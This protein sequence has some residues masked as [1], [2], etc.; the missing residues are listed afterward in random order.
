MDRPAPPNV[1]VVQPLPGI[2]DMIW[3]L[4]H[5]RAIAHHVGAPVTLLAKP[6]SLADQIFQAETTIRDV[7]WVDRNP[8]RRQG[9]HDGSRGWFRLVASLRAKRFSDVF[10]LHH[11]R[12]LAFLMMAAGIP[13]R[14][15]YGY[16]SQRWFLNKGPYL[17]SSVFPHH[18]FEQANAWLAAAGIPLVEGEP[19]LPV[20]EDARRAVSARFGDA[21]AAMVAIGVG[22]SEPYKQWGAEKFAALIEALAGMGW[23]RT[24]LVGG[25]AEAALIEQ[26]TTRVRS[27]HSVPQP[28]A[29]IGWSLPEVAALFE[30]SRFYVGNDTGVMNMA[31][32]VG[33]PTFSL[34]GATPPFHHSSRIVA[35]TPPG[36]VSKDDGMARITVDAV[37]A[38]IQANLGDAGSVARARVSQRPDG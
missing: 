1:A 26:I 25:P 7:L 9:A 18:P 38:A 2:G 32:A 27:E 11:S 14:R 30:A 22:S 29:A 21:S 4:P 37:I 31:A 34:F 17:P 12:T 33:I 36:G 35:V 20:S 16:G 13:V 23:T 15:G 8:E 3:H 19:V 5:I 10:I 6:R 28:D 24:A